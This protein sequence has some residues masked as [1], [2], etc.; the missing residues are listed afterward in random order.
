MPYWVALICPSSVRTKPAG[1]DAPIEARSQ[2]TA[3]G[4]WALQFTPRVTLLEDAVLLEVQASQRLFGGEEALRERIARE[5][6]ELGCTAW[7]YAPTSLAALA[8]ARGGVTDG[9]GQPL[10]K[11][12]ARLPLASLRIVQ[13]HEPVLARL[14]CRTLGDVRRLPRGGLN[15]RFVAELLITLDQA[16]GDRP[17]S[18]E[19]LQLPQ[20]FSAHLE[21][22]GRIDAAPALMVGARRLLL[23]MQGWLAARR[24]GV[25]RF[26]LSW[27]HDAVRP[28]HVQARGS[29]TLHTAEV[30]RHVDHLARLLAE[31]LAR[32]TLEAPV[33]DLYL[34]A[35]EVDVLQESNESL[36]IE[37]TADRR[38]LH[39]LL[40]R[41]AARLGPQRIKRPVLASD[42]RIEW[43]QIWQPAGQP[44]PRAGAKP[45]ENLPQPTWVLPE[46]LPLAMRAHKPMYQGVL[47]LMAG[48]HR[49]EA[50]WWHRRTD[51]QADGS[52]VQSVLDAQRD[53]YVALS[54]HAGLLWVYR[55]RLLVGEGDPRWFLHG[56]F[57]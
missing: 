20:T 36:L 2:Q 29:L 23:Q 49:I 34:C 8:L 47:Q 7:A 11:L 57:A 22:P 40:E 56:L 45:A 3:V 46:P 1:P 37:E 25:R 33:G 51:V 52:Q 43:M 9:F 41:L 26:T 27:L 17:E 19:W 14:G 15:R 54:P 10:H 24:A 35:D 42:H 28:R 30:T 38:P 48:P 12:L 39:E 5:S 50:G 18:Y 6:A 16:H 55:E 13:A 21:L 44:L 4:L 53:Y 32:V 31:H